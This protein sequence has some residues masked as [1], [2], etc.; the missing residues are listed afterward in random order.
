MHHLVG[1]DT[2]VKFFNLSHHLLNQFETAETIGKAGVI[3]DP[4]C[5]QDLTAGYNFLD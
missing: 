1:F 4:V 5:N 2:K 3:F